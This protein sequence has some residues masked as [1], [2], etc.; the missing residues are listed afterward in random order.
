MQPCM[1]TFSR[2]EGEGSTMSLAR[3]PE[4]YEPGYEPVRDALTILKGRA[5]LVMHIGG[6][7]TDNTRVWPIRSS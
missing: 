7:I 1:N 6:T 2:A 3:E 4:T 5:V